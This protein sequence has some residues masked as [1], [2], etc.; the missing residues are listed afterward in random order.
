MEIIANNH[1]Y[2]LRLILGAILAAILLWL[3]SFWVPV[4]DGFYYEWLQGDL[5]REFQPR[6]LLG[7]FANQLHFGDRGFAFIKIT[8]L[9]VWLTLIIWQ[10][11]KYTL[12]SFSF[13]ALYCLLCLSSLFA[14]GTVTQMSFGPVMFIDVIPYLLVMIV[15]L[16]LVSDRPA[17]IWE[18]CVNAVMLTSAVAIHEKSVFDI[19]ILFLWIFYKKGLKNSLLALGPGVLFCG[20]F[21]LLLRSKNL[22]GESLDTYISIFRRG[23]NFLGDS[24]S[25]IEVLIGLGALGVLYFYLSVCFI[26]KRSSGADGIQRL[27]LTLTMFIAC[28]APLTVAWDTNRLVGL[29]W[30]PTI[31]LLG[32]IGADAFSRPS[33]PQILF[34]GL[35]CVYQLLLPP[36]LRFP[37]NV[38]ISYNSYA[39]KIYGEKAIQIDLPVR[40]GETL[41]FKDQAKGSHF[42]KSGWG[43]PEA[44]GVWSN[45]NEAVIQME[46]LDPRVT[47]AAIRFNILLSHSMP[48]RSVAIYVNDQFIT[49][50]VATNQSDNAAIIMLPQRDSRTLAI[51]FDINELATPAEVGISVDDNRKLGVGLTAIEFR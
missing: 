10:I 35:L 2:L 42:L 34:L 16:N 44:W 17:S 27:A 13:K 43:G 46:N 21:L 45:Q 30:L 12:G 50:V 36:I 48:S 24:F 9:W 19:G 7:T 1:L 32:E 5:F 14:F 6:A 39:K 31:I 33:I 40:L 49:K 20:L 3:Y 51:R 15:Y 28:L 37:P 11:T 26:F 38:I 25:L 8:A 4:S 22:T 47:Q 18:Y 23:A 29:I 41:L